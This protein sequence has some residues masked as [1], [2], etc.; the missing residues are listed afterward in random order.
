MGAQKCVVRLTEEEREELTALVSKGRAH[1]RSDTP[2][3]C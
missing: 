3:C 2:K 1:G